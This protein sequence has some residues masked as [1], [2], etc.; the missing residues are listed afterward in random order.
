MGAF[1]GSAVFS[2]SVFFYCL[3]LIFGVVGY[4][5]AW[6]EPR[7]SSDKSV[8]SVGV[9]TACFVEF[10]LS[11]LYSE[12]PDEDVL[13]GCKDTTKTS[14][15]FDQIPDEYVSPAWYRKV[16]DMHL[17]ALILIFLT[18][19]LVL[20]FLISYCTLKQ[21][22][23][24]RRRPSSTLLLSKAA[25][26]L[27]F[28][29]AAV[30]GAL[31]ISGPFIFIKNYEE[32]TSKFFG[33]KKDTH[34][35]GAGLAITIAGGVSL[36]ISFVLSLIVFTTVIKKMFRLSS[37]DAKMVFADE[38]ANL[39][40]DTE[41]ERLSNN[42]LDRDQP[43]SSSEI[44]HKKAPPVAAPRQNPPSS[45][46]QGEGLSYMNI[47]KSGRDKEGTPNQGN[48][49]PRPKSS[50]APQPAKRLSMHGSSDKQKSA[51]E[52][53]YKIDYSGS[54]APGPRSVAG[55]SMASTAYPPSTRYSSYSPFM[56]PRH[57]HSDTE[58]SLAGRNR[59]VARSGPAGDTMSNASSNIPQPSVVEPRSS[60]G[61][62]KHSRY[63][64]AF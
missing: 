20:G 57:N 39:G 11:S 33:T 50:V 48:P 61:D 41:L 14:A 29:L 9:S 3:G 44:T 37:G 51:E 54:S 27:W 55:E 38:F 18:L 58:S 47:P 13:N 45:V 53:G 59:S 17:A 28:V 49:T 64:G 30:A 16:Q 1:L 15:V 63:A 21:Q 31:L 34:K 22:L 6:L 7:P 32:R 42:E 25:L 2:A 52:P 46:D 23:K 4:I 10:P 5:G 40:D 8:T 24:K 35:Y 60:R 26:G 43:D 62:V 12:R 56:Q 19:L 36:L